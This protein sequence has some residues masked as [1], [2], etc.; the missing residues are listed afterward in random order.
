VAGEWAAARAHVDRARAESGAAA[1]EELTAR[2]D[3]IEAL[4]ALGADAPGPAAALA[5]T[6][7]DAAERLVL[8]EVACEALEVLGRID[9]WVD[10]AAAEQAFRR[11]LAIAE[12]HDL[13]V[14]RLR[15]LHELGT[16][17]M[18]ET[19]GTARLEEAHRLA[20]RF[21]TLA[22]AADLGLQIAA[23]RLSEDD[24]EPALLVTRETAALARRLGLRQ[25]LGVALAFEATA[26]ARGGRAPEMEGCLAAARAELGAGGDLEV[27]DVGARVYLAYGRD[28]AA[29][30]LRLLDSSRDARYSA[31]FAGAWALLRAVLERSDGATAEIHRRGEPVEFSGRAYLRYAEAVLAGRRGEAEAAAVALAAGD[32]LL[33]PFGWF[34][35]YGHRLV[36]E[37]ALADGWG[38]PVTLVREA[39]DFFAAAG[40]PAVASTC[41]SLLRRAGVPV[42]R[43]GRGVEVPD[44]LKRFGVTAREADVLALVAQGLTNREIAA[45]LF[46]SPRTVETH[47]ERLLAK[48][49][50]ANRRELGRVT[51]QR[52]RLSP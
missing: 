40:N 31:P 50:V 47:V 5:R 4:A 51:G 32:A 35:H 14:W 1:D 43:R 39:Q 20:L 24:P 41:R 7:L 13:G 9:R 36:A 52:S 26:H 44:A 33:A 37:A 10:L 16:I 18:L 48:T 49:G 22:T 29:G 38:D 45:R 21:G 8:P 46:L 23:G 6:A 42:R 3:S 25:A 27:L 17:D 11:G 15:A 30:A 19:G 2:A 12:R 34:R 28:D